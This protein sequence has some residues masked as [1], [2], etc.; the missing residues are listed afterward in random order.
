MRTFHM[1]VTGDSVT[2]DSAVAGV[3]GSGNA[4]KL[5][6]SFDESWDGFAKTA[7]WWDAH[8]VQAGDPSTLTFDK[9]SD[10]PADVRT[11][12]LVV[13]P[14]PL[15]HAGRCRLVID[16]WKDGARGRTLTQELDV[17]DAP[18]P[19][20]ARAIAAN[21]DTTLQAQIDAI[22]GTV[23]GDTQA[24]QGYADAAQGS[25]QQAERSAQMAQG[26]AE[27]ASDAAAEAM[28][29]L[30]MTR[31]AR[32]AAKASMERAVQAE[33]YADQSATLAEQ[34]KAA[35]EQDVRDLRE[36]MWERQ[37]AIGE[38][39]NRA[40]GY[41][42]AAGSAEE[43]AQAARDE[44][45]AA[46][47]HGPYVGESGAWLVWDLDAGAYRD[48]GVP[49][50]GPQGLQGVQ[51]PAGPQGVNGVAVAAEGFYAFNVDE[52]GHL[53]LSYTGQSAPDFAIDGSGHLV[54]NI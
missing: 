33:E 41:A 20:P 43:G 37:D 17:V 38:A 45:Q 54:L 53:I 14:E 18:D 52:N 9:L 2:L 10:Y 49:A 51:G 30:D 48:T 40:K 27:N 24:A 11:Y 7:C 3:R 34:T 12:I 28:E 29:T 31:E 44:A 19:V 32:D 1:M 5:V 6:V 25:A 42:D 16:G 23:A 46:V 8:G 35:V 4:D 50:T 13:P 15:R 21:Q 26:S 39:E 36:W 47:V 22:L